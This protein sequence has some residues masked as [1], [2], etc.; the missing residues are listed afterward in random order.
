MNKSQFK[1]VIF[2]PSTVLVLPLETTVLICKQRCKIGRLPTA[3]EQLGMTTGKRKKRAFIP[4]I[5]PLPSL[6]CRHLH[7][8]VPSPCLNLELCL[9]PVASLNLPTSL[10]RVSSSNTRHVVLT[11]VWHLLPA[12]AQLVHTLPCTSIS[13]LHGPPMQQGQLT[14][15][16]T[17]AS[18]HHVYISRS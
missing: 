17:A 18:Q 4:C 15:Q 1:L 10:C 12:R 16:S 7:C 5:L 8:P 11:W 9:I 2:H 3:C 14:L 13:L 6:L